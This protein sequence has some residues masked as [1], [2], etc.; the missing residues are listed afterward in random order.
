M[1][2]SQQNIIK[3]SCGSGVYIYMYNEY[4]SEM[5]K[6]SVVNSRDLNLSGMS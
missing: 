2:A 4:V 3:L 5:K 1:S 6:K